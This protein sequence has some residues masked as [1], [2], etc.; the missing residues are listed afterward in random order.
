M[1]WHRIIRLIYLYGLAAIGVIILTIGVVSII[2][3]LLRIYVFLP[4]PA[5]TPVPMPTPLAPPGSPGTEVLYCNYCIAENYRRLATAIAQIIVGLPL[6][7]YHWR[8]AQR[9]ARQT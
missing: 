6:W 4:P 7:A 5:P 8:L 2:D 1:N 3:V 9:E